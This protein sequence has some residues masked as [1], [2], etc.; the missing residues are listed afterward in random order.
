MDEDLA[1]DLRRAH[2]SGAPAPPQQAPSLADS[3]TVSEGGHQ[4]AK[5][6]HKLLTG[7]KAEHSPNTRPISS[8]QLAE[9]RQFPPILGRMYK[10]ASETKMVHADAA[11]NLD[12]A[13]RPQGSHPSASDRE[14]Q[15]QQQSKQNRCPL[16]RC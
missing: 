12:G 9:L 13:A 5:S 16:C 3:S 8:S 15:A 2:I 11:Q 14:V 4:P 7:K 1:A 10:V 6:T